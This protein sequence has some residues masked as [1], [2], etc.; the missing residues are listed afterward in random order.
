MSIQTHILQ[1]KTEFLLQSLK[2]LICK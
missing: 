1:H 2:S